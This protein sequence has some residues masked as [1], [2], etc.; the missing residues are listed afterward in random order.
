MGVVADSSRNPL[1]TRS[2]WRATGADGA[3]FARRYW[4]IATDDHQLD[5]PG[6]Y[7]RA[8]EGECELGTLAIGKR[9]QEQ[10]SATRMGR[11]SGQFAAS[12]LDTLS[13]ACNRDTGKP[14]LSRTRVGGLREWERAL[15]PFGVSLS[16]GSRYSS[17]VTSHERQQVL[18]RMLA[19]SSAWWSAAEPH[20]RN[21]AG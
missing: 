11:G 5:D 14:A 20:C 7:L 16:I 15:R 9:C 17:I 1:S 8:R 6:Q 10:I 12:A 2:V 3:G 21:P 4:F 19:A 18:A 13:A